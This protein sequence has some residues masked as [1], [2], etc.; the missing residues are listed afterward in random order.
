MTRTLPPTVFAAA[1][2]GLAALLPPSG[3]R[4]D[5]ASRPVELDDTITAV[6]VYSDQA[7]VTRSATIRLE[8]GRRQ[9]AFDPLPDGAWPA[10]TQ[11]DADGAELLAVEVLPPWPED[12]GGEASSRRATRWR[13]ERDLADLQPRYDALREEAAFLTSLS[14][15]PARRDEELGAELIPTTKDEPV[16][17]WQAQRLEALAAEAE[18]LR[19]AARALRKSLD[20]LDRERPTPVDDGRVR[21]VAT[22]SVA[23]A[24]TVTLSATTR[25]GGPRWVPDYDLHLAPDEGAGRVGVHALVSQATGE[26]W[27]GVPLRLS[28]ATPGA[29]AALPKLAAW[30]LQEQAPPEPPPL[31]ERERMDEAPRRE[32]AKK[33]SARPSPS[34]AGRA[35]SSA[36][37]DDDYAEESIADLLSADGYGGDAGGSPSS[38]GAGYAG[39]SGAPMPPPMPVQA[40]PPPSGDV[41][42]RLLGPPP[43]GE[44]ILSPPRIVLP[45][46]TGP[47]VDWS[48]FDPARQAGGFDWAMQSVGPVD[49]PSDGVARRI[50]L[51]DLDLP[52]RFEHRVPAAV[53]PAAWLYAV[54]KQDGQA[55]L[56]AGEARVFQSGDLLGDATLPM[57]AR[58]A[59]FEVPLGRDDQLRV[60]RKVEEVAD[61]SG[62]IAGGESVTRTVTIKLRNLRGEPARAVVTDR[63]PVTF[64]DG[65]KVQMLQ[66]PSPPAEPDSDGLMT[67]T[68]DLDAGADAAVTFSYVI[69]HPRNT[70]LREQ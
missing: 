65:M 12:R 40:P 66:A 58:G 32:R 14:R 69:K 62:P 35:E 41:L 16:G 9:V 10:T 52:A 4:A 53:Q 67:W 2:A 13:L 47:D 46:P 17:R 30:Y 21:G 31:A 38:S 44:P 56:L 70:A 42:T 43:T 57:S 28:T 6:T 51:L 7:A 63:V 34:A 50:P 61:R 37:F 1:L 20:A 60:E 45:A 25:I 64:Q 29:A 19:V 33:S 3:P 68:I 11:V 22:L 23:R 26:D 18:R 49:L 36:Y 59:T 27:R 24:G 15:Q 54:L 55:P 39:R 48:R 8:A 5:E